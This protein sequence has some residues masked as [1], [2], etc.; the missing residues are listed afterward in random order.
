[1]SRRRKPFYVLI[2]NIYYYNEGFII[3]FRWHTF[4]MQKTEENA[5]DGDETIPQLFGRNVKKYRRQARLTQEQ[6]SERL[7]ISQKHLSIIETGTQ[8]ASASLIARISEELRVSPGDLFGGSSDE[9][10]REIRRARDE[11]MS[12]MMNELSRHGA[13]IIGEMAGL[14]KKAENHSRDKYLQL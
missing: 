3:F 14:L 2:G 12:M 11:I 13:R 9:V 8:F 6:L 10:L 1:M 7:G 5:R 4:F